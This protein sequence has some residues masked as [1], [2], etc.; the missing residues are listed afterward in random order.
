[1]KILRC[2]KTALVT[3]LFVVLPAWLA[4][5]LFL[6]ILVKL[7]VIVKPIAGHLPSEVNHPQLIALVVFA[8]VLV[9]LV[10]AQKVDVGLV[11]CN[12]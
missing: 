2:L 6:K 1:M 12:V 7:G 10:I 11:L 4:L 5:L 3:G 9:V 8:I